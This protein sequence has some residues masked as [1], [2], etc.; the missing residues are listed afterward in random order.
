M[1]GEACALRV[2]TWNIYHGGRDDDSTDECN[3]RQ[4]AEYAASLAPDVFVC[5]ETYGAA[6][7]ILAALNRNDHGWTYSG[8]RITRGVDD[9]LWIFSRLPVL[10]ELPAPDGLGIND[11]HAGGVRVRLGNG[12]VAAVYDVWS[13]YTE[14]W[15]GDL[16]DEN[17]RD[18]AAGREPRHAEADILAADRVPTAMIAD[19][20]AYADRHS[21]DAA[22][23]AILG[24]DLNTVASADWAAEW[25]PCHAGLSYPL[26]AT[27]QLE[28]AGFVDAFRAVH[29][30]ACAEPGVSWSPRLSLAAPARIDLAFVRG[31]GVTV[32]DARLLSDRLPE[33]TTGADAARPYYSDHAALLVD[34]RIEG[35]AA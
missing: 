22:D 9:N 18:A 7:T 17:V 1:T 25:A 28:D 35:S 33:H 2:L 8:R 27:R 29:P 26:V 5:I 32:D 16:I 6:E 31:A 30:D 15:I 19:F 10:E 14:P 20:V 11:F 4:A 12:R 3:R 21:P 13:S 23:A 24:G 34:Y